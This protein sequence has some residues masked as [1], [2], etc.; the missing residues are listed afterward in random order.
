MA[1]PTSD[2][3]NDVHKVLRF[4][5][6][7]LAQACI[8]RLVHL[9]NSSFCDAD[10]GSLPYYQEVNFWLCCDAWATL[11]V[12]LKFKKQATVSRSSSEVE[13]RAMAQRCCGLV[14]IDRILAD[15]H[16]RISLPISLY[17]DNVVAMY[18]A[19]NLDFHERKKHVGLDCHLVCRYFIIG[20]I[21][22]KFIASAKKPA[23]IFIKTLCADQLACLS[24]KLKVSNALHTR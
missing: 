17:C 4:I 20:F 18:I 10:W 23:G 13:Y 3:L 19:R 24:S 16:I 11:A 2:H 8:T 1:L 15:L 5:K 14:W 9:L 12:S 7:S 21:A 22:S 6:G